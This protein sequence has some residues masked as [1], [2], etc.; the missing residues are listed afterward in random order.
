MSEMRFDPATGL[1][2]II[3]PDRA[4]RP[5]KSELTKRIDEI[6]AYSSS[7]PFCPGNESMTPSEVLSY[8]N[9]ATGKWQVRAFAN[10][11]PALT[12]GGST[13]RKAQADF[14]RA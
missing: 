12:P 5:V 14:S 10:K 8:I 4:K 11:F 2:V 3:A 13:E 6:P 9:P 7:C 1:W